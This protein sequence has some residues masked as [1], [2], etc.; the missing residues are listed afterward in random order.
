MITLDT[1]AVVAL[2]HR[3]DPDHERMREAFLAATPPYLIPAFILAEITYFLETRSGLKVLDAFLADLEEEAFSL[4]C[5]ADTL[6]RIRAL[7]ARY[8]DL[9]LGFADASVIA[10][11]EQHGGA[12][13]TLD[14]RHFGLVARE[15]T[16]SVLP[17]PA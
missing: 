1:S 15:G 7:V 14:E 2:L 6:P 5:S 13:L 16:L 12:V 17:G 3:K 4:E 10:C 11:A 9:P 8:A